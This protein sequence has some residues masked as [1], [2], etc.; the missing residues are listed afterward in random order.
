MAR[1]GDSELR[2]R[3]EEKL[4]GEEY[5]QWMQ[6]APQLYNLV[7]T[8]LIEWPSIT[9][10]WLPNRQ[11]P[12]GKDYAVQTVVLGTQTMNNEPNYLLLAQVELPLEDEDSEEEEEDFKVKVEGE[13]EEKE[14]DEDEYD[15]D[16][17]RYEDEADDDGRPKIMLTTAAN[18]KVHIIQQIKHD[19][20]VHRARY[21]PQ[22]PFIIA[23]K[24]VSAEVYMFD[25]RKHP[26]FPT[27]GGAFSPD[28]RLKGHSAGGF[29]L[30]WSRLKHGHLLSGSDDSKIC[31]WNINV[32][33]ENKVLDAM[34]TFEAHEGIVE[35]VA[36]HQR[37]EYLFGSVGE[38]QHLHIWDL[39]SPSVA[40]PS[41]TVVAHE[42]EVNCLSFNHFNEWV[43]LTGS[44]DQTVKLFDLR[45]L[46]TAVHT[47]K[48]HIE[49]IYQVGWSPEHES[50]LASCS[51]DRRLLVWDISR[52]FM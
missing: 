30:S 46:S 52:Y 41:Q 48:S 16:A 32:K 18:R 50:I 10:E 43:V 29:G 49:E 9:V 6:N 8:Q 23:T 22:N 35:D 42:S 2:R 26:S 4:I 25:S 37:H 39:R 5:K 44:S 24:T 15:D 12:S 31:L 3:T 19:G 34:Q 21:M 51:H 17:G 7:I 40:K 1:K 33:P 20:H 27:F 45:R 11:E 13:E 36:W 14:A 47:F 38:D 28:L